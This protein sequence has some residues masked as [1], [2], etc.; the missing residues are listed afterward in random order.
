[1]PFN[2]NIPHNSFPFKKKQQESTIAS[3][4]SISKRSLENELKPLSKVHSQKSLK[5]GGF[6]V[7]HYL[8]AHKINRPVVMPPEKLTLSEVSHEPKEVQLN[9]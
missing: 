4:R 8:Q 2:Q 9:S 5:S 3:K 6:S 1:M 7:G